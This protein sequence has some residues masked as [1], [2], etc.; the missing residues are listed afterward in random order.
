MKSYFTRVLSHAFLCFFVIL[1]LLP[2]YL[3]FV[4]A[5]NEGSVMMQSHI[6]IVPGNLL[7]KNF[8]AVM[9]EGLAVTGGEPIT[10]ML[11][12]SFFM[13]MAI[14]LGKII[15]ALG[16]AFALVYF[17]FPFKKLCFALIFTTM[18]LPIEVR[19]VPTFQVVASFGLLNSY[20]GLTLPLFVS[21]TGTFLFRQFFKT[22]PH[23]LVD[24]A[25]LDGAGA[26]RFFFDM[27]LPLSKTQIASLFVILFVYGWNQYLWPLVVTTETKMATVVMGIRYLAGVADQIPQWNYIM[28]VALIALIPPCMVVL[29]MQRW[30]EK[31]LK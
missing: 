20:T 11:L 13:A 22:I 7:L 16:S 25:K 24:A 4:A 3:A 27:V 10:S 1:M 31:G 28:T 23:E 17:D 9:A 30:F 8:K 12:N 21:A 15:F 18:M 2:V 6:P 5:S 26:V 19:I 29:L 14:A